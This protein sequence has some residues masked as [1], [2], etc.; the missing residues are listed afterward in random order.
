MMLSGGAAAQSN[1]AQPYKVTSVMLSGG[2][3][4]QSNQ[5]QPYLHG[6]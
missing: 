1:Q 3:A 2:A 5:A 4:A 6:S